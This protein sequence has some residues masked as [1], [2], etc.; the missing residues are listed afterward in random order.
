MK[1][2]DMHDWWNRAALDNPMTAILSDRQEWDADEFFATGRMCLAQLR[3]FAAAATVTLAGRR[4]MDF[5]CGVGR[6]TQ[7]LA[8]SYDS[9]VGVDISEEM[10]RVA[11]TYPCRKG[12]E[13]L[14]AAEPPLPFEDRTFDCVYSTIVVQ[15]IP[16]PYNLQY[17]REFMRVSA[18]VVLFDAPSHLNEGMQGGPGIFMLDSRYVLSCAAEM[19]FELMALRVFTVT[20]S[21]HYQYLLRRTAAH[22]GLLQ[23]VT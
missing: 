19:G 20:D 10:V 14:Q 11:Y 3:D 21:R 23:D 13:Y 15:H 2:A 7:A 17:V 18:D 16:F 8:E 9:V 6:L 5:G 22:V 4:A 12:I 1:F